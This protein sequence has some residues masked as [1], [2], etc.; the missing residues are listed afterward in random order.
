L[1]ALND[2][3]I[4]DLAQKSSLIK[5]NKEVLDRQLV[6]AAT[7]GNGGVGTEAAFIKLQAIIDCVAST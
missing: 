3:K 4:E 1:V 7:G 6:R 5:D 2:Q